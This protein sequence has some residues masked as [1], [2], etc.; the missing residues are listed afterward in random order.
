M[1][2]ITLKAIYKG[3]IINKKFQKNYLNLNSIILVI[4]SQ[5]LYYIHLQFI[6]F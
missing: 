5:V 2:N 1:L 3:F 6:L 4:Q